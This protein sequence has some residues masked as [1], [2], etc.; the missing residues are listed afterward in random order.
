[1]SELSADSSYYLTVDSNPSLWN[2][3]VCSDGGVSI[4]PGYAVCDMRAILSKHPLLPSFHSSVNIQHTGQ[5]N[6]LTLCLIYEHSSARP[7]LSSL[8]SHLS[9][10]YSFRF[11][12]RFSSFQQ[13]CLMLVYVSVNQPSYLCT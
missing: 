11:Q 9:S 12:H 10:F 8:L 7:F 2:V 6:R 5:T 1:V 4:R 13:S 3:T